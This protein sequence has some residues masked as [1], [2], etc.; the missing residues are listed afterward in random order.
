MNEIVPS[1]NNNKIVTVKGKPGKYL[2]KKKNNSGL[3]S[4]NI[5]DYVNISTRERK[6]A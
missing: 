4:N 2:R 3:H 6:R 5:C 1:P